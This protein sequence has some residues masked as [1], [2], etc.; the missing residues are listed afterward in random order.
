[1][2]DFAE[3]ACVLK[4]LPFLEGVHLDLRC[5]DDANPNEEAWKKLR[6][7][8]VSRVADMTISLKSFLFLTI[9]LARVL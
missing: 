6:N 3:L 7:F 1:M 8:S 5:R 9:S 4:R 2:I